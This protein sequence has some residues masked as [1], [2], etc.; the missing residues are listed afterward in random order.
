[1]IKTV[2]AYTVIRNQEEEEE[3]IKVEAMVYIMVNDALVNLKT[4]QW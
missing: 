2:I 4:S 3:E 1:M